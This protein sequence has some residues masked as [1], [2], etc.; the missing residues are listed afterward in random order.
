MPTRLHYV[1]A[2]LLLASVTACGV[3]TAP[4]QAAGQSGSITVSLKTV[5]TVRSVTIS[6][7]HATFVDCK[8]GDGGVNTRSAGDELGFPNG[9][10]QVNTP[11]VISNTGIASDIDISGSGAEPADGMT[12]WTLC[13]TGRDPAV[14]CTGRH[15]RPGPDQYEVV[16][17]GAF[18]S[19]RGGI[20]DTPECDRIL[21]PEGSCWATQGMVV[22]EGLRLIGPE[23]STDISTT[24]TVTITWTPVPGPEH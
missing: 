6:P 18:G 3:V 14:A 20:T 19:Q 13:N 9:T 24:W 22:I 7:G 8:G 10:C 2:A 1:P 4:Q 15:G 16:N 21:G 12:G 11:I 17:F 23:W 5:P